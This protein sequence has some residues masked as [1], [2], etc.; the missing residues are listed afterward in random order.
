MVSE[1]FRSA[2]LLYY[3][4]TTDSSEV[5]PTCCSL[6][7][8]IK[9]VTHRVLNLDLHLLGKCRAWLLPLQSVRRHKHFVQSLQHLPR[10]K[11]YSP[12]PNQQKLFP[13]HKLRRF[14]VCCSIDFNE[15]S[16]KSHSGHSVLLQRAVQPP[17]PEL[18]LSNFPGSWKGNAC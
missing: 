14:L 15:V 17:S 6:L 3:S 11:L 18:Q 12:A 2:P 10:P 4:R 13:K 5:W 1:A 16:S 8:W 7:Y 9:S